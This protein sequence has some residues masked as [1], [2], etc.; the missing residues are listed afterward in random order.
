MK[1]LTVVLLIALLALS[2]VFAQ[3]G[4]ETASKSKATKIGFVV[5][6]DESDQGYTWNFTNGMNEAIAKFKKDK[7]DF[8]FKGDY[9]GKDATD[10]SKTFDLKNGYIENENTSY[11]LFNYILDDVVTFLPLFYKKNI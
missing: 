2:A 5:I 7:V 11:P 4:S 1:K 3:G 8:V 10:P 6:N 9:T